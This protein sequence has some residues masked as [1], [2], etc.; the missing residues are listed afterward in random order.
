[1]MWFFSVEILV[2]GISGL[3]MDI[4][5]SNDFTRVFGSYGLFIGLFAL[6]CCV[7]C[8]EMGEMDQ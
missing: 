8:K 1:M 5:I 7:I 6:M 4:A 3:I 2:L